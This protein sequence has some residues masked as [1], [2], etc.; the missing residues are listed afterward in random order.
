MYIAH[1]N[2][3][4]SLI[5]TQREVK[6]KSSYECID[7]I[8]MR[9]AMASLPLSSI[10]WVVVVQVVRLV[11]LRGGLGVSLV[12]AWWSLGVGAQSADDIALRLGDCVPVL[13]HLGDLKLLREKERRLVENLVKKEGCQEGLAILLFRCGFWAN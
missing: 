11:G 13:I 1:G 8:M 10:L 2:L 12:G 5:R 7:P 9:A 3:I 6:L 4:W